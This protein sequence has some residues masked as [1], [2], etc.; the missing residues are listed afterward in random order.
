MDSL[1][2]EATEIKND[3]LEI[4]HIQSDHGILLFDGVC[5]FCNGAVN[6]IMD[7]DPNHYFKFAA[8]Q[9]ESG[10]TLLRHFNL[11]TTDFDTLVYIENKSMFTKSSAAL[12]IVKHLSGIWS[13]AGI[14]LMIPRILRDMGYHIRL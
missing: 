4:L 3:A 1:E 11:S 2:S 9:S 10:Q 14:A 12:R 5:N 8:L 6:F 13:C 7:H